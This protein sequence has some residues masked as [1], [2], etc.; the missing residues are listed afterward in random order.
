MWIYGSGFPKRRDMLKPAWEPII[1]AYKPAGKRSMQVDECR[2]DIGNEVVGTGCKAD[3]TRSTRRNSNFDLGDK[4]GKSGVRTLQV[5]ECRI[6]TDGEDMGDPARFRGIGADRT[7]GW[8]RPHKHET[9]DM[10][11]RAEA[12]QERSQ[13]L[14]RWPAN[15]CHDGSD[16]VMEAFAAFAESKSVASAGRNGKDDGAIFAMRRSRDQVRGHNDSGSASRFF[17]AAKADSHD[18]WGSKHPTVKP[19]ELLKWLVPLVTPKGGTVLDPFAGSGTTGVAAIAA[20]RNAVLV[21]RDETYCADIRERI[22][23]YEGNGRHSMASRNRSKAER[24]ILPLFGISENA[25]DDPK[26]LR[27]GECRAKT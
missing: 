21:E 17:Y 15:V 3:G 13:S 5:D 19:V 11:A 16:E 2:I 4:P 24:G 27:G 26:T 12:A 14:G 7:N 1:M 9:D 10:A 6:P 8:D 20:G 22:A 25:A 18:R 23:H